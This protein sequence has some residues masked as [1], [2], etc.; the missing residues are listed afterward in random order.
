VC[1]PSEKGKKKGRFP[2]E[3][4]AVFGGRKERGGRKGKEQGVGRRDTRFRKKKGEKKERKEEYKDLSTATL[5]E[6]GRMIQ[7][8]DWL[9]RIAS[10][11]PQFLFSQ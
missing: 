1:S 11:R 8:Q 6:G 9:G 7:G 3:I 10:L 2:V 4:P 5:Q